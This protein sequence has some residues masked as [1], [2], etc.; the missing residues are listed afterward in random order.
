[1]TDKRKTQLKA[2]QQTHRDKQKVE[3]A[4]AEKL[5]AKVKEAVAEYDK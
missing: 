4:K 1:M 3:K 5:I 2:A